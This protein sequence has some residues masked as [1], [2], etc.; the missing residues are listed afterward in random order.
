M[1]KIIRHLSALA[2][3]YP[4]WIVD[5]CTAVLCLLPPPAWQGKGPS[6]LPA[7]RLGCWLELGCKYHP[8]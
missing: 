2:P 5:R 7:Q 8:A 1:A 3:I 6:E 4:R